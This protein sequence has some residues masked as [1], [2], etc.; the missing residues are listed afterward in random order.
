MVLFPEEIANI[1][2]GE[3]LFAQGD[4]SLS[5]RIGLGCE[6]GTSLR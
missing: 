5:E 6:V 1:I 4:D 3:I 2:D